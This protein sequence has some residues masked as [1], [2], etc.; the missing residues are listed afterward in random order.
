MISTLKVF[1][2]DS[3]SQGDTLRPR[4]LRGGLGVGP[5]LLGRPSPCPAATHP[6]VYWTHQEFSPAGIYFF[7]SFSVVILHQEKNE[8]NLI[9]Y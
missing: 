5:A 4:E 1:G 2:F 9:H 7:I 3:K 8:K 6:A